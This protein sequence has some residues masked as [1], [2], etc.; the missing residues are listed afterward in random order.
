MTKVRT[1]EPE[2]FPEFWSIWQ[3]N[4]RHTDGR[5]LARE[6]Y[7]KHVFNGALPEDIM[8][9]ARGFFRFMPEKDR[10]YVPLSASWLNREAYI[11]WAAKERAYQERMSQ[12]PQKVVQIRPNLPENHFSRQWEK[13]KAAE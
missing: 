9:G 12:A 11:D 4:M 3:P 7:R 5:G 6:A 10:P 13:M 8:D 2:G 1:P